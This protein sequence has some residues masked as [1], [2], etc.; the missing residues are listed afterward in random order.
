[1]KQGIATKDEESI[2]T[3]KDAESREVLKILEKHEGTEG[4]LLAILEEIQSE[5]GYL[6]EE[7]LRTVAGKTGRSLVDIYGIA[8]FYRSFSLKP[9]GK[10]L[11]S[12]CLGTACHVRGGGRILEDVCGRLGI[13]PGQTTKDRR[14]S[15]ERV[16]CFGSCALAPVVVLDEKVYGR[17]N[18]KKAGRLIAER[19]K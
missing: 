17:L 16:A 15:V 12:V 14:F 3:Q 10:H 5:Y 8:T 19:E 1:M 7:A 2:H 13:Q 18:P 11:V 9:R 6:P 4:A